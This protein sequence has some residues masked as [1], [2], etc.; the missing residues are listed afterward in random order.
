MHPLVRDLYKRFILVGRDYPGGLQIIKKKVK[1]AFFTNRHLE[2]DIEIR[3]AVARG[4]WYIRN[5][6][7]AIIQFKKY[8]V[9][10]ERYSPHE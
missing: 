3:R 2:D 1:E 10:K 8:R 4:R 5:E 9:M 7:C 6:L